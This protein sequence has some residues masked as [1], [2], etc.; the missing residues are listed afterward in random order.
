MRRLPLR[1]TTSLPIALAL[2][3][4]A[5]AQNNISWLTMHED[6]TKVPAGSLGATDPLEK[7]YDWGDLDQDGY[8][9]LVVA[10]KVGWTGG[11]P[12][13]NVLM[14]NEAGTLVD[15]TALYA[16]ASDVPGDQGFL[17]H[18]NDRDIEIVDVDGDGWL[19]V[20]TC[21]AITL[22][23]PKH[24]SHPRVYMN[25]GLDGSANWLGLEY[26]DARFPDLGN[27]PFF[28]GVGSGDV[29]GDGSPELYFAHYIAAG[30]FGQDD[31]LMIN[32]GAGNFT[33]ETFSRLTAPMLSSGFGTSAYIVDMNNDGVNDVLRDF[34]GPTTIA[35]NDPN[36]EGFFDILQTAYNGAAYHVN[37]GDLNQD[38][39]QDMIFSDDAT[40]TYLI[41]QGNDAL[42]RVIWSTDNFF[43]ADGGFA[44]NNLI[45]DMN[46]DGWNEALVT[47]VDVDISGCFG[48]MFI[49]HNRGGVPGGIPSMREEV[50]SGFTG[51]TG[52]LSSDLSGSH[53]V[54]VFDLDN[55]GDMD[56]ILG[57]CNTTDVWINDSTSGQANN[58]CGPAVPNSNATSAKMGYTGSLDA[59]LNAFSLVATDMPTNQFGFFL[60]SA[61]QGSAFPASVSQGKL[62]LGGTI[63]R[64]NAQ[65]V[66]SGATGSFTVPIDTAMLP[67]PLSQ[68]ILAGQTWNFTA[69]FRD[70][71]PTPTSNFTDGIEILFH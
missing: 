59:S 57:R 40:D 5:S 43:A 27:T 51:I 15:R 18:T 7:D 41:N 55:D 34:S 30:A 9:D 37:H 63:A 67:N 48:R 35:Y 26:Q 3:A 36:N 17:E 11:G 62:C 45:V 60:I 20:V 50:G 10:R 8:T 64:F 65:I 69:W 14:M 12:A 1:L 22:N 21:T 49:H 31:R 70:N 52:I 13:P 2:T 16:S 42:G 4:G 71:N 39:L 47:D 6:N 19:D 38:G 54:A 23:L 46:G 66:N 61:T 32:D 58:Y 53:D 68:P 28:C 24:L 56:M 25:L 44:G 33:D 29:T